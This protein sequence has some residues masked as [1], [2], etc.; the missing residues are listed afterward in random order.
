MVTLAELNKEISIIEGRLE[1]KR[2]ELD[3]A[4]QE[5]AEMGVKVKDMF[6]TDS[7]TELESIRENLNKD[8]E[9]KWSDYLKLKE[10]LI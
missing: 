4:K 1:N 9:A 8:I 7:Q 6:G 5:L 10:S 3:Q 2:R